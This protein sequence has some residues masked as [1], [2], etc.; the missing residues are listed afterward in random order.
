MPRIIRFPLEQ[1]GS[2]DVEIADPAAGVGRAG[3]VDETVTAASRTLEDALV[4][5]RRSAD[6]VLRQFREMA[7]RPDEVEVQFGV[8]LTAEAGALI[9]RT[10]VEGQLSV[11]LTWSAGR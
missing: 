8:R 3:R 7:E 6:A 10:G 11:R 1:G 5:V 2:V 9:A 4:G